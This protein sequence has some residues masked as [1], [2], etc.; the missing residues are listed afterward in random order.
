MLR[1]NPKG[2]IFI[3]KE[4]EGRDME[5]LFRL[6]LATIRTVACG[7]ESNALLWLRNMGQRPVGML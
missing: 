2:F 6:Y 1:P 3:K 7:C 4:R 5:G